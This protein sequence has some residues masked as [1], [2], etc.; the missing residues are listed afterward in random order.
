MAY[1]WNQAGGVSNVNAAGMWW[2][3]LPQEQWPSGA[4]ERPDEKDAWHARYGD[5][6]QQLVFIG[7]ELNE[8]ALRARL[9]ACLLAPALASAASSGWQHL[10]NPFPRLEQQQQPHRMPV[11]VDSERAHSAVGAA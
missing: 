11:A 3:A 5:R 8:P 1:E 4:G 10:A 9:D 6:W 7:I 2:A